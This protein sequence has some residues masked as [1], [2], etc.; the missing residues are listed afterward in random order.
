MAKKPDPSA[1]LYLKGGTIHVISMA[2]TPERE[3]GRTVKVIASRPRDVGAKRLADDIKAALKACKVHQSQKDLDRYPPVEAAL[4]GGADEVEAFRHGLGVVLVKGSLEYKGFGL[5][6]ALPDFQQLPE[7]ESW[8]YG[9]LGDQLEELKKTA[10]QL[11]EV[12]LAG[13]AT[14][15]A[16]RKLAIDLEALGALKTAADPDVVRNQLRT[17][18]WAA[19]VWTDCGRCFHADAEDLA[20]GGVGQAI[21]EM[22]PFF[23][24]MKV[25]PPQISD[26]FA[27]DYYSVIVDGETVPILT[28]QELQPGEDES[29]DIWGI[30]AYRAAGMLN[31]ILAKRGLAER[32]YA[33]NDAND[34]CFLLVTPEMRE[35]IASAAGYE[36]VYGPY[37]MT[38]E[39]PSYGRLAYPE[40]DEEA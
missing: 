22:A 2:R 25:E 7:D 21:N 15:E 23:A 10:L 11:F 33:V 13:P 3:F 36:P 6:A 17:Q 5:A 14:V 37:V 8:F 31:N 26:D 30:S 18:G 40:D 27:D 20:E 19:M 4:A 12:S 39:Y 28:P 32:A 1:L 35:V 38:D 34:L 24:A 29:G 9:A 16:N